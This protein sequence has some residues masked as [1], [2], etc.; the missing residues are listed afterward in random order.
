MQAL[1]PL[2]ALELGH[3]RDALR[4]GQVRLVAIEALDGPLPSDWAL[5]V[6]EGEVV[7]ALARLPQEREGVAAL[8][9]AGSALPRHQLD[10]ELRERVASAFADALIAEVRS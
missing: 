10:D 2:V 8:V 4:T 5:P 7:V 3:L 1:R 6:E 9:V